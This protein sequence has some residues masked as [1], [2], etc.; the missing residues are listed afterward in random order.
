LCRPK[1]FADEATPSGNGVAAF[2][3]ARLGWILGE[4][5]YLEAAERTLRGGWASINRAPQAHTMMLTALEEFLEPPQVVILRG[6]GAELQA[7]SASLAMIYAPRR[8]VLT[9]PAGAAGLPEALAGKRP[10]DSTVAYVCE[11]PQCSEPIEELPRLVRLL[12]DGIL[13]RPR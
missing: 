8:I 3:L 7:W 12:R 2:S 6:T 10:R 11:G 5:R 1:G 4:T 13:T 9:I